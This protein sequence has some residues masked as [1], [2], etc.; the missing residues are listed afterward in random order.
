MPDNS[1]PEL[2]DSYNALLAPVLLNSA[3]AALKVQPQTSNNAQIAVNNASRAI[4][5]LV[6][7][8]ADMG[9]YRLSVAMTDVL[10][11]S[12]LQLSVLSKGFVSPC[13]CAC[14]PQGR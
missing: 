6:L 1:P 7:N 4:D 13:P 2:Q 12:L 3:L 9:E 10:T 5:R 14:H 8:N 11:D